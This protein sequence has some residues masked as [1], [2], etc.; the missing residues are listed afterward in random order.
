MKI[1]A[2]KIKG[3]R[4]FGPEEIIIPIDEKLVGQ[5]ICINIL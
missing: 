2:L 1:S 4:S 5:Q 3:F